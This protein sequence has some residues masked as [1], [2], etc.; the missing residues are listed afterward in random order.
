MLKYEF[1]FQSVFAVLSLR[2]VHLQPREF[3]PRFRMILHQKTTWYSYFCGRGCIIPVPVL[4][5]NQ[6]G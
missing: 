6:F 3:S 2:L 5:S 1:K 4:V